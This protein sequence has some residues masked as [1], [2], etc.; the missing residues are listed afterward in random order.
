[1]SA[2]EAVIPTPQVIER[3]PGASFKP[4]APAYVRIPKPKP[5]LQQEAIRIADLLKRNHGL[6]FQ[7]AVGGTEQPGDIRLEVAPVAGVPTGKEAES[8][9]LTVQ[10]GQLTI[11]APRM[12][13]WYYA[14]QTLTQILL[15][16]PEVPAC[17][18]RDW[19]AYPIRSLHVDAARKYF[20]KS[21]FIRQIDRLATLKIN[22]LQW[23]FSENEGFRLE[24]KKHPE[25]LSKSYISRQEATE[26]IAYAQDNHVEIVPAFD[27]PGHL[28]WLLRNHPEFR[29]GEGEYL[30]RMLDYSNPVAVAFL[31]ELIDEFSSLFIGQTQTWMVGGDEVFPME[32]IP[33]EL[34]K[35]T[36]Q[37]SEYAKRNLGPKAEVL[38]GYMYFLCEID[39]Y[40]RLKGFSETR[41]WSDLL[42]ITNLM[43]LPPRMQI[44]YWTQWSELMPSTQ[45]LLERG[46]QLLNVSDRYFYYVISNRDDC[47]YKKHVEAT[48]ILRNYEPQVFSEKYPSP[49]AQARVLGSSYAIW[50]DTPET[51]DYEQ[52]TRGIWP[53]MAAMS[54]K[55]WNPSVKVLDEEGFM[56]QL[57]LLAKRV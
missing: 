34:A 37:L 27:M 41:A 30:T 54:Q 43:N 32:W 12:R 45:K 46:H 7:V 10:N 38:D 50:C 39:E 8:Y 15:R 13:G 18:I 53:G 17:R 47:A 19:A 36:P 40:L 9:A 48:E 33:K 5:E 26:I 52:I 35:R 6:D 21:W 55:T 49:V 22:Q 4:L 29:A 2:L 42:Y 14:A 57:Y 24:S 51:E 25:I 23:H 20:P 1:M 56:S 31:K 11:S 3:L 44:A 28:G 16:S